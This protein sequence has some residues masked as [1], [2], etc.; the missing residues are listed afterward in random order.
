MHPCNRIPTG[1]TASKSAPASYRRTAL[2]AFLAGL[3]MALAAC[4]TQPG[5][6][7]AP[8]EAQ[9]RALLDAQQLAWNRG[10]IEDM[11][12]GYWHDDALRFDTNSATIFG[13]QALYDR[14]RTRYPDR[15]AMGKLQFSD[16]Q[17]HLID[18]DHASID[19]SWEL[20]RASDRPHGTFTLGL[21]R[22]KESWKIVQDHTELAP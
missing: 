21:R 1:A 11:M 5:Q 19:G 18:A 22:F 7:P 13:W 9:I 3:L 16:M 17:I 4:A 15:A 12:Q 20:Q 8:P 2:Y 6:E 14:Y 10:D